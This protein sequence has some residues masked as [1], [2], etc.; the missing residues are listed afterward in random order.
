LTPFGLGVASM[1]MVLNDVELGVGGFW[2]RRM[3]ESAGS[4]GIITIKRVDLV[5]EN[6]YNF[7]E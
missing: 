5:L 7:K 4:N 6:K 2:E 1:G 3:G